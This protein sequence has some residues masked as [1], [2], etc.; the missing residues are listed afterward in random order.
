MDC[1]QNR[2]GSRRTYIYVVAQITLLLFYRIVNQKEFCHKT[3]LLFDKYTNQCNF[4]AEGHCP[5][6][7]T[8]MWQTGVEIMSIYDNHVKALL[9]EVAV[10]YKPQ[11]DLLLSPT[12]TTHTGTAGT[13]DETKQHDR[14]RRFVLG[15]IAIGFS[16]AAKAAALSMSSSLCCLCHHRCGVVFLL[17]FSLARHF[18]GCQK[19]CGL[20]G[21]IREGNAA[22]WR[23]QH[24]AD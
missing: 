3:Q 9:A 18:V 4:V 12:L 6:P 14:P 21:V 22:G 16:V 1:T 17:F 13:D 20:V 2:S 8:R 19:R 23:T 15:A 24:A 7:G 11:K 10:V 5:A